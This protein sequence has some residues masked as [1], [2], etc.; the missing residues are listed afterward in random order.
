MKR[1]VKYSTL[2]SLLG[3]TLLLHEAAAQGEGKVRKGEGRPRQNKPEVDRFALMDVNGD[4]IV[5]FEEFKAAQEKRMEAIK[6]KLG[7]KFDPARFEKKVE[8]MFS[9]FDKDN[10]GGLAREE[11]VAMLLLHHKGDRRQNRKQEEKQA[12]PADVPAAL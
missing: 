9:R 12:A 5:S 8:E 1:I 10:S 11:F 3:A 7:D 6:E 2:A 4:G